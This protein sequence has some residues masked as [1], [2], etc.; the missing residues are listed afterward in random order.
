MLDSV[1]AG[2]M[3]VEGSLATAVSKLRK[4]IGDRSGTI[5]E[6]V[7]RIGY[8]LTAPVEVDGIDTPLAPR[9]E[10]EQGDRVPG[11]RQWI[12]AAPLG[13][14]GAADVWKACHEKTGELRVF[15]FAE[16]PDTLRALKREAALSRL[17]TASE[18]DAAP[19]V[20]LFEWNFEHAPYF[21]ELAWGGEDLLHWSPDEGDERQ[22]RIALAIRICRAVQAMH[23]VGILHKDLKPANILIAVEGGDQ[24]VKLVDFGSGR[25]M[26]SALLNAF[27]VTDPGSLDAAEDSSD[28]SATF[29]Y[30]APELIGDTPPTVASDIYAL[31]LIVFQL[32]VGDWTRTLSPGWEN[33]IDD[34]ILRDD[35]ACAAAGNPA[36]RLQGAGVLADRL[37]SLEQRR[38]AAIEAASTAARAREL[39]RVEE[40]RRA[41][42]PWIR[43]A[44]AA[45]GIG[46]VSSTA[47]GVYAEDQRSRAVAARQ[48]A[49]ASYNFLA[50]DVLAQPDPTKS[51]ANESVV[52]AVKRSAGAIDRRFSGQPG[53]AARLYVAMGR[54]FQKRGEINTA[55]QA[56]DHADR[57]FRAAG[58]ADSD[59]AIIERLDKAQL[60]AVSG[61]LAGMKAAQASVEREAQALGARGERDK[62]GFLLATTRGTLAY[63]ANPA[64]SEQAFR[65][66]LS[67]ARRYPDAASVPA[68]L[69]VETSLALSMMRQGRV[70][71]AEPLM[72]R[73]VAKSSALLGTTHA[74]TLVARLNLLQTQ[75]LLGRSAMVVA[76]A[77]RLLP[78]FNERFGPDHRSTLALHSMR[79]DGL[80]ALG[81][82]REAADDA[83][84]VWKGASRMAGANTHQA[85]V[86]ETDYASALCQAGSASTGAPI[87]QDA[88]TRARKA[89]AES[90]P[91]THAIAYYTA[92][93]LLDIGR[94]REAQLLLN[95]VDRAKVASI[96]GDAHWG[97]Q[98]DAALARIE[99]AKGNRKAA[100][101]LL[102]SASQSMQNDNDPEL[103]N[104]VEQLNRQFGTS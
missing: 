65:S 70:T 83:K 88:L 55:S 82:Y 94:Y 37:S 62:L 34:P 102:Q 28:R 52:E 47:F 24:R 71:E 63:L 6:T 97:G 26:D 86:G 33:L 69:K 12:L 93:C 96:V 20:R 66:A 85:L 64:K 78:L 101:E 11:R 7:P 60:Q 51:A 75:N 14:S 72:R 41:R 79:Y 18:G 15:K 2:Y 98:V 89:F 19:I 68:Q 77:S 13:D 92:V 17:L 59:D 95:G 90:Y 10:F 21:L 39:A 61:D 91:L 45:L 3:V 99:M 23:G 54:A 8:R 67:I 38:E 36:E 42:R 53:I 31:G 49:E 1:W 44:V 32:V 43:A 56:Y 100:G 58:E 5:I 76:G 29:A 30:R 48:V 50:E 16:T 81:R 84:Q 87:A 57:L 4:V 103:R 25:L 80:A 27:N 35:I 73:V 104:A 74:D 40:R 46:I 22:Q 9:F